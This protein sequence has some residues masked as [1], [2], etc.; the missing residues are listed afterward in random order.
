MRA[1][2]QRTSAAGARSKQVMGGFLGEGFL[3]AQLCKQPSKLIG[4]LWRAAN[5]R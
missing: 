1:S 4:F 3:F 2:R 5:I